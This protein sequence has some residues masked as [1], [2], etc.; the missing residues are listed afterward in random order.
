MNEPDELRDEARQLREH[1]DEIAADN[2]TAADYHQRRAN[3]CD[4]LARQE[5][6][7]DEPQD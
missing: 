3:W 1:A 5:E 7:G 6:S 4:Y 2:P